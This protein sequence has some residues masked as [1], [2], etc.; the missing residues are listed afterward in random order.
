LTAIYVVSQA[1][2]DS[3]MVVNRAVLSG[4]LPSGRTLESSDDAISTAMRA[5]GLN[6]TKTASS[7]TYSTVGETISFTIEVENTGNVTLTDVVV[8]DTLTGT[9]QTFASIAPG[10]T[11]TVAATY[12]ITQEDINNGSVVNIANAVANNPMGSPISGSGTCVILADQKPDVTLTKIADRLDYTTVGEVVNFTITAENTGNV[13][14]AKVLI[15]DPL[16]GFVQT[17]DTLAVGDSVTVNT[18][19]SI[20]QTDLDAGTLINTATV[21]GTSPRN[22][23]AGD[24]ASV[25]LFATQQPSVEIEKVAS[26]NNYDT[27]G[28]LISYTLT[29]TNT[30]NVSLNTVQ[31]SD[32]LTGTAKLLPVLAPG[33]QNVTQAAYFVEQSDVD[34][35]SLTNVATVLAS[36]PSN[37]Q[38]ND[39]DTV[40]LN[41]VRKPFIDVTKT[42]NVAN[43]DAVGD[44]IDYTVSVKNTGNETLNNIQ[45]EDPLTGLSE[46]IDTLR[47]AQTLSFTASYTVTQADLDSGQVLNVATAIASDPANNVV[48]DSDTL[49][50]PA[51]Q[52]P[53]LSMSMTAAPTMYSAVGDVIT[54]TQT[55]LNT[56]NVTLDNVT[57]TDPL[58]GQ[59]DLIGTMVPGDSLSLTTSYSIMQADLDAGSLVNTANVAGDG[60]AGSKPSASASV[61]IT[62]EQTRGISLEKT[63][64]N[65]YYS[66]YGEAIYYTFTVRNLGN[67]T[68]TN[69]VLKDPLLGFTKTYP[70]LDAS[71]T[72]RVKAFYCVD[73]PDLSR[74]YITNIAELSYQDP[75][76]GKVTVKD[77]ATVTL[78]GKA[79]VSFRKISR[80]DHFE[81]VG[82]TIQYDLEITNTGEVV[83]SR[84]KVSDPLTGFNETVPSLEAGASKTMYTEYIIGQQDIE[85]GFVLNSANIIA[86]DP[87]DHQKKAAD[88]VI[89]YLSDTLTPIAVCKDI[90]I[91]LD[92]SG[93]AIISPEMVDN[94]SADNND[95][96]NITISKAEFGCMDIGENEVILYVT[97]RSGNMDSCTAIVAVY[98]KQTPQLWCAKETTVETAPDACGFVVDTSEFDPKVTDNCDVY[99]WNSLNGTASLAGELLPLGSH[100]IIWYAEDSGGNMDSCLFSIKVLDKVAPQLVCP[101][102]T[103]IG[104]ASDLDSAW[105]NIEVPFVIDNCDAY[106]LMNDYTGIEDASGMYAVGSTTVTYIVVDTSG[107]ADT[108]S[109][110]VTVE[111]NPVGV[112]DLEISDFD[113][114][115]YPNPTK[116][117]VNIEIESTQVNDVELIV[118]SINGQE[119]FRKT[120]QQTDKFNF[121]LSDQVSGIYL[122]QL[123]TGEQ[124][125]IKKLILDRK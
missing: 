15:S 11:E 33:A 75:T 109:F 41:A 57:V 83:L 70:T 112:G 54:Y 104:I 18:S 91:E 88:S 125:V 111:N 53:Q 73:H 122:I 23:G 78:L 37:T 4:T 79:G 98:D 123:S 82:D 102:D 96:I 92:S 43:F 108:C 116:G 1:D 71:I 69:V 51:L 49:T 81:S 10:V 95:S 114:N 65:S 9:S 13:S 87:L 80:Q 52:N 115:M 48:T 32:P 30:G 90:T 74:G 76:L 121:D 97:D 61:T 94:G 26:R 117:L 118:R 110:V 68:L 29:V 60:P 99:I 45:L 34:Y 31:I 12:V 107:N 14:L 8:K 22:F 35:G 36:D 72:E 55:V 39:A 3:G 5:V 46:F 7:S 20:T 2:I 66:S 17:I 84:I 6:V 85:R 19:Y 16:T 77:T 21:L 93:H 124:H 58:T 63:A 27:A 106:D 28:D 67:V 100:E 101:P 119:V 25:T 113:I 105:I 62:G 40:K 89:T 44:A 50:V 103:T 120:Y 64:D 24:Q 86:Y 47:V 59:L 42:A 56:G 38:V